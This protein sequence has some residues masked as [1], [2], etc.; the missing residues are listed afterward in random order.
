ME[1]SV[2]LD[3]GTDL[4][5]TKLCAL[6]F[7][8]EHTTE[9][10]PPPFPSEKLRPERGRSGLTQ[11]LDTSCVVTMPPGRVTISHSPHTRPPISIF[12]TALE[13]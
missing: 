13:V 12:P 7:G 3:V 4:G 10:Q 6:S 2:S 1:D 8:L 9:V 5:W 11:L